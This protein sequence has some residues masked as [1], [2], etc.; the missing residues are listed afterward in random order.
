MCEVVVQQSCP[1]IVC[2][3]WQPP[4]YWELSN[5]QD[6]DIISIYNVPYVLVN[7]LN[8]AICISQVDRGRG[9]CY[10]CMTIT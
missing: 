5:F 9:K 7:I 8:R 6:V 3:S 10:W 1:L 4:P 2:A